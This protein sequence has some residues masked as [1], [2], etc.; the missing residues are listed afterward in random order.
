MNEFGKMVLIYLPLSVILILGLLYVIGETWSKAKI[1]FSDIFSFFGWAGKGARKLVVKSEYEG[2]INGIIKD[3]NK[4]FE[5]PVLPS[6]RL[7]WVDVSKEQNTLTENEAI[8]CLS[9]NKRDHNLNFFNATLRFVSTALIPKAKAYL[10]SYSR[11]AIDLL[12]THIILRNNR[13][14]VLTIFNQ[15]FSDFDIEIKKEFESI[16]PTND[17]GLFLNLLLPEFHF[18]G[19]IIN[20]LP[21]SQ[22]YEV[23]ANRFLSWF[24]EL[25]TRE[26]DEHTNL[27]F[28]SRNFKV[29]II[30]IGKDE[31][32]DNQGSSAYTKWADFYATEDYNSVYL[33]ARGTVGHERATIVNKILT[34]AKGFEQTNKKTI[35]KCQTA[36]GQ[37]YIVTCYALRPNRATIEYL[38]WEKLKEC[39]TSSSEVPAIIDTVERGGIRVNIFGL[40][41]Y[42]TNE[43]LSELKITDATRIF[44]YENELFLNIVELNADNAHAVLSNVGTKSD[45]K[46]FIE[47]VVNK[48]E[49][50]VTKVKGVQINKQGIQH[51][52]KTFCQELHSNI[53]LPKYSVTKSRFTDLAKKFPIDQELEVNID[54]FNPAAGNFVGSLVGLLDPWETNEVDNIN[55]GDVIEVTVK[56]INDFYLT[57][58]ILEGLD[59]RISKG[60]LSWNGSECETSNYKVDNIL[61]GLVIIKDLEKKLIYL[62]PKR[63]VKT[64]EFQFFEAE[65]SNSIKAVIVRI[66]PGT[67]LVIKYD[68]SE[69][70]G[71]IP[72]F[73]VGW[74][75]IGRV[76]NIFTESQIV[77][78]IVFDFLT[79]K[80][81][82]GFSLKRKYLHQFGDWFASVNLDDEFEGK[83]IGYFDGSAHIELKNN[84]FAVQAFIHKSQ[85]SSIAIINNEDIPSYLPIDEMFTF[86]I[87]SV[88]ERFQTIELTRKEYLL[89]FDFPN[90]GD[91]FNTTY[92]KEIHTKCFFYSNDLEGWCQLSEKAY[93]LGDR[94]KVMP[95][96]SSSNEYQIID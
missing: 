38:A 39:Y 22:D 10:A 27:K 81:R 42:I 29:G 41:F 70:T 2:V 9:Y 48:R 34:S 72:W 63:L 54:Y 21:P 66:I 6:C 89:S 93:H 69:K 88:E 71:L 57:C 25:A 43:F 7:E 60:E 4:N 15:K 30:L 8:I 79:D 18:Y 75:A 80:N 61:R 85:I 55:V 86:N 92:V 14:E 51:G 16:A 87:K 13:K 62:S 65:R 24:K 90:Y 3:Y 32:W 33:L 46:V 73:E 26:F 20:E 35:I 67:G 82:I 37:E 44:K 78:P 28:I 40:K 45:P 94:V 77:Y 19:E 68:E 49:P 58:E 5:T 74:G 1:I 36:E 47:S 56:E 91:F 53:Y 50:F 31:T 17:K 95:L 52:L 23:E 64:P 84:G 83:V 11:I 76:E 96:S 59:C 12:T